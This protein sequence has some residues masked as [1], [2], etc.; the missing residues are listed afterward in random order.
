MQIVRNPYVNRSMLRTP[1]TFF[2]RRAECMRLATRLASQTPQSVAIIGERRIGKSSL[3]AYVSHPQIAATYLDDPQQTLFL[4]LDFQEDR[5]PTIESFFSAVF[6]HV[7]EQVADCPLPAAPN[8]EGMQELVGYLDRSGY[9]LLLLLDEFDRVTRSST[10]DAPFYAFLRS[11]A[12]RY[13]IAYITSSGRDLQQLCHTEEIADSP[14]FNIFSTLHLGS[15]QEQE[16][17][18]L[19]CQPS[20]DT[21]FALE[22]HLELILELGGL[23]PFF[24]QIACSTVFELLIEDGQIQRE[25][26]V[27]RFMEEAQPHFQFYWQQMSPVERALCNDLACGRP[28]DSK[29]AEFQDLVRRGLAAKDGEGRLFSS[30][31]ADFL[32]QAYAREVGEEPVEVQAERLRSLEDELNTARQMQESLLPQEHPQAPGLDVVG[33]CLSATDVG[34]DFYTYLWLDEA[35]TQLAIV[36]VDVMGHG[37]QGAVTAMRFSETLRYEARGRTHP[38]DILTGLNQALCGTLPEGSFVGCCIGVLDLAERR[39]E[40]SACGQFSPLVYSAAL[41]EVIEL[42]MGGIPLGIKRETEYHSAELEL[43]TGDALLFFSD[44]IIEA[45]DDREQFYGEERLHDLFATGMREGLD[46]GGLLDRLFWDV[47]RF[48]SSAGQADDMT[49]VVVQLGEVE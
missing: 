33:R 46:A 47:G 17:V 45:H 3:M 30:L 27:Q 8:Y 37:M 9:R 6:R 43:V 16:A 24:L 36:T 22:P 11:L 4:F 31:F 20:R 12:G 21:L 34:G 1:E 35:Q 7:Q 25:R 5:C 14:F 28:I 39:L 13:N 38:V 18:E 32:R 48:S 26:V 19:V 41:D 23:F 15:L 2:G 40:V 10:F 29:Q 42:D 49:A 44:G